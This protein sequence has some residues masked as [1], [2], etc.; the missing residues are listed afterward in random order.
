[1]D[2][3]A[4][5]RSVDRTLAA[6]ERDGAPTRVLAAGRHFPAPVDDV[7]DAMT[8][9]ARLSRWFLPVSGELGVGGRF[10]FEGNAGGE[11]LA[12]DR[13]ERAR[14]TWEMGGQVSW[15]ELRLTA[16]DG[17]TRVE[18]EHTAHVD[19]DLWTQFGPGAVGIGWDLGLLGLADH[20]GGGSERSAVEA[21]A[22]LGTPA[23]REYVTVSGTG[24]AAAAVAD[25]EDPDA[26]R[27]AGERSIAAYTGG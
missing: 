26:A 18:I 1:M 7:W 8:D 4:E 25:G 6:G 21:Q 12:C 11:V 3:A 19:Q 20:L 23:G 14:I 13:P 24:W 10:Q 5:A 17:G 16:S 2:M 22:L 15:L 27:A 9:P